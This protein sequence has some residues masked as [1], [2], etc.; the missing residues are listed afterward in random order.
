MKRTLFFVLLLGC[1][2]VYAQQFIT[3]GTI[4][5]EVRVN[6]YRQNEGNTWFERFKDQTPQFSTNYYTYWFTSDKGLYKFERREA[7][8]KASFWDRDDENIWYNDYAGKTY[9][10]LVSLDGYTQISGDLKKIKW[11]LHPDDQRVIAGFNCRLAETVLFDSVY[12]FAYY[13]DEIKTSGGPMGLHGLPGMI[14]GV[15]VPRLYTSWMATGLKASVPDA[16]QIK[17]PT[18]GRKKTMDE[19]K[20]GIS[21]LAKSWGSG[22]NRWIDQMLWQMLL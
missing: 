18:K 11:K 20:K 15:T 17:A 16:S 7:N 8:R 1:Q 22:T 12:V 14:M 13:T 10:N 3:S 2:Q 6:L 9:T 19:I 4:E 5:Y 21:D